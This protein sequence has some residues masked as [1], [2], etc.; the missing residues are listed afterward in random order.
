MRNKRIGTN[1]LKESRPRL[2]KTRYQ[3]PPDNGRR[4]RLPFSAVF[5]GIWML[6]TNLYA[7]ESAINWRTLPDRELLT[8]AC[9]Y[10]TSDDKKA[11]ARL[12]LN[13]LKRR[14]PDGMRALMDHIHIK[15]IYIRVTADNWIRYDKDE[16]MIAVFLEY[17]DSKHPRTRSQ[18]AFLLGYYELPEYAER[19][20]PLLKHDETD[21]HALRTLGKWKVKS[22]IPHVRP[23]LSH[24]EE[25][26][27]ILAANALRDIATPETIDDLIPLLDD[28]MFTVRYAAAR[29]LEA[30]GEVEPLIAARDKAEGKA[31]RHL[32]LVI[33]ALSE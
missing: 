18:A 20:F 16:S 10:A 33:E 9:N 24:E 2:P 12:A 31:K 17:L 29:A 11:T 30:I 4:G 27:R 26:Y 14:G 19:L 21:K 5:L 25:R 3:K 7:H 13:E 6:V 8:H 1:A 15:N 23:Y 32:D 28:E 22:A